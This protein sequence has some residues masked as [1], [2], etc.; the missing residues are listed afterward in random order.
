VTGAPLTEM[1]RTG[2]HFLL[3]SIYWF[4]FVLV[5]C[6]KPH[7]PVGILQEQLSPVFF[8]A[9]GIKRMGVQSLSSQCRHFIALLFV[10]RRNRRKLT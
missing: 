3:R 10:S 1:T 2:A 4:L 8:F 7:P 9:R 5:V 6:V